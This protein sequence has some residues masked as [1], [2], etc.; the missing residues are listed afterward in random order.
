MPCGL[1]AGLAGAG[2]GRVLGVQNALARARSAHVFRSSRTLLSAEISRT[3]MATLE[4]VY[5]GRT[6][7]SG[8]GRERDTLLLDG[9][10]VVVG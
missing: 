1:P 10:Y 8:G 2:T 3:G 5:T 6:L 7:L 4:G 9:R